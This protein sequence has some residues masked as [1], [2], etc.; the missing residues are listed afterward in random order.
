MK[1]LS[2]SR[3]SLLKWL[4]VVLPGT[5]AG[6]TWPATAGLPWLN[7]VAIAVAVGLALFAAAHFAV[8][9]ALRDRD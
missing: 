5:L 7:R 8:R 6:V 1:G 3:D 9:A 2:P 4:S